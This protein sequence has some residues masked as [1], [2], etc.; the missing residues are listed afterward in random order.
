M[1]EQVL[2]EARHTNWLQNGCHPLWLLLAVGGKVSAVTVNRGKRSGGVCVLEFASG[3]IGNFHMADSGQP[4]E[5]HGFFGNSCHVAIDGG[6]PR[7]LPTQHPSPIWKYDNLCSRR[8][9]QWCYCLGTP[10]LC[11]YP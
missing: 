11:R 7:G 3:A 10:K 4:L 6:P 5:H 1:G 9:R 2:Q 8:T